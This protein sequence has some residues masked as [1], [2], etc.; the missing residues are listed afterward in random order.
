MFI[1]YSISSG[2]EFSSV[3]HMSLHKNSELKVFKEI[4]FL[5]GI[6]YN[7]PSDLFETNVYKTLELCC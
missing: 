4:S 7:W 6:S 2:L 5:D 1:L 3:N